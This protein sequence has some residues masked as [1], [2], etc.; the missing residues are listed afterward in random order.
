VGTYNAC[1]SSLR[2]IPNTHQI[3]GFDII[4]QYGDYVQGLGSLCMFV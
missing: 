1:T 3:T 4:P 2:H